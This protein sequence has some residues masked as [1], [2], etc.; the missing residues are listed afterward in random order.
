MRKQFWKRSIP[1]LALFLSLSQASAASPLAG[2]WQG[3]ITLETGEQLLATIQF[4]QEKTTWLGGISVF[5]AKE[6]PLCNTTFDGQNLAFDVGSDWRGGEKCADLDPKAVVHFKGRLTG[7]MLSGTANDG[8]LTS[9]WSWFKIADAEPSQT[10]PTTPPDTP[11]EI[12]QATPT[13]PPDTPTEIVQATPTTPPDTPTEIVQATPTTPPTAAPSPTAE[14]AA[15]EANPHGEETP[16]ET[17]RRFVITTR[18]NDLDGFM[19]IWAAS[20]RNAKDPKGT[21]V[22]QLI[23]ERGKSQ[24]TR[25]AA[26]IEGRLAKDAFRLE[27]NKAFLSYP[28]ITGDGSECVFTLI[29]ERGKWVIEDLD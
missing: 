5:G 25:I 20:F 1:L 13:T 15:V 24:I 14:K 22:L 8:T 10:T 3:P 27:G 9:Q 29:K 28:C 7:P 6:M 26:R 16:Y 11:T 17:A 2:K 21:P 12:V 18:G 23:F 4:H 19:R